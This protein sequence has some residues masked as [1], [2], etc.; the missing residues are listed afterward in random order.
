MLLV[1][2]TVVSEPPD[3]Q[4]LFE[5]TITLSQKQPYFSKPHNYIGCI[6][7]KGNS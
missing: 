3:V 2:L 7:T 5:K 1:S 6:G 4:E